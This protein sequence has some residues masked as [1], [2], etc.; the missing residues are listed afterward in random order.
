MIYKNYI[1]Y[2]YIM[3]T[4]NIIYW[5]SLA[6]GLLMVFLTVRNFYNVFIKGR[7]SIKRKMRKFNKIFPIIA[8]VAFAIVKIISMFFSSSG[9]YDVLDEEEE[10]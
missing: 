6:I 5:V 3:E 4:H 1:L 8:V 9:S 10:E 7:G 2:L